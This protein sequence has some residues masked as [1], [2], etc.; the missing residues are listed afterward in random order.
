MSM[1]RSIIEPLLEGAFICPYATPEIFRAI[2]NQGVAEEVRAALAPL[3]RTL[4][5][6]GEE[7]APTTYF[8]RYVDLLHPGD[9]AAAV[10]QLVVIRDQL[11]PC[12]EFIRLFSQAGRSDACIAPGD[13]ISFVDLLDAIECHVTY[14]DQ[15]RDLSGHDFF[16]KSKNGKDNKDRLTLVLKALADAGYLAKRSSESANYVATGKMEYI[17]KLLGWIAEYHQLS[18]LP[19]E[20][21]TAGNEQGGLDLEG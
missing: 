16:S 2:S 14:R 18:P 5:T 19:D 13:T 10:A 6:L 21:D 3:G 7:G 15:L 17:Y 1:H 12:L 4:G 11:K 20:P 8:A 9:R